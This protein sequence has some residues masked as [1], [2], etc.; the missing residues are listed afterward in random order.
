ML[1]PAGA[2]TRVA[3]NE[4]SLLAWV[5]GLQKVAVR[6]QAAHERKHKQRRKDKVSQLQAEVAAKQAQLQALKLEHM[7]LAAKARAL[8][9]LL[10]SAGDDVSLM[11]EALQQLDLKADSREASEEAA[12]AAAAA[13][14]ALQGEGP[15]AGAQPMQQQQQQQQQRRRQQQPQPQASTAQSPAPPLQQQQQQ[16]QQQSMMEL[17]SQ[18]DQD[19]QPQQQQQPQQSAPVQQPPAPP[20]PQQQQQQQQQGRYH[21]QAL[22][23][24]GLAALM[25]SNLES[26]E[27]ILGGVLGAT[28]AAAAAP[29]PAAAAAAQPAAAAL[30]AHCDVWAAAAL[31][32]EQQQQQQQQQ[33]VDMPQQQQQQVG[34]GSKSL[35][36]PSA[37]SS[38]SWPATT[39]GRTNSSF[40]S[41]TEASSSRGEASSSAPS[42]PSIDPAG[43][44]LFGTAAAALAAA[45]AA[46]AA[47][48]APGAGLMVPGNGLN[49]GL[50]PNTAGGGGRNPA[51]GGGLN[52]ASVAE[53]L[54]ALGARYSP[55][56]PNA[57]LQEK[58]PEIQALHKRVVVQLMPLLLQ[59]QQEQ[60]A[61]QVQQQQQQQQ[62]QQGLGQAGE[63]LSQPPATIKIEP[64]LTLEQ[65]Q[66]QQQQD[67][68]QLPAGLQQ[69]QQ[70]QHSPAMAALNS[71]MLDY[72]RQLHSF[73]VLNRLSTQALY[74]LNIETGTLGVPPPPG[75]WKRVAA[76]LK[77]RLPPQALA[78]LCVAR[79]LYSSTVMRIKQ[80]RQLLVLQLAA[81]LDGTTG[82][83]GY[84]TDAVIN[85]VAGPHCA[86]AQLLDAIDSSLR[87]EYSLEGVYQW[88][89]HAIIPMHVLAELVVHSYPYKA[90]IHMT[91]LELMSEQEMPTLT[92][93]QQL[94]LSQLQQQQDRLM[95]QQQQAAAL[96]AQQQQTAAMLSQQHAAM[97]KLQQ[98][99]ML[100]AGGS[101]MEDVQQQQ[102]QNGGLGMT[103]YAGYGL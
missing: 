50:N 99:Q 68:P 20:P 46:A 64:G 102:Q 69:Q 36:Q 29:T 75:H 103:M 48:A 87:K 58:L 10:A 32:H 37:C 88:M 62:Q 35:T 42:S 9:Q 77:D 5:A 55:G 14:A 34:G 93:V 61:Q 79:Q 78:D 3:L 100:L 63:G 57:L 73:A 44:A 71:L 13:V 96:L 54:D 18:M 85:S 23:Q 12:A 26:L 43:A 60:L 40:V 66:Q 86:G 30:P 76:M 4:G 53:E 22:H 74:T 2:S 6:K 51:G 97:Q 19:P 24:Q 28:P 56:R 21:Y 47:A 59:V 83:A 89:T 17:L 16:Q 7:A 65:Q 1:T 67:L 31:Q 98:Q 70:Q 95:A 90:D 27:D 84:A 8:D 49:P 45:Q 11:E 101:S 91:L 80:Q 33:D 39:P 52:P 94:Q 82:M 92:A 81:L 25:S 72:S 41:A 38:G 15:W